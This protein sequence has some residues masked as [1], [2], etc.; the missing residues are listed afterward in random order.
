MRPCRPTRGCR[1]TIGPPSDRRM[2]SPMA[3]RNGEVR[4]S[5]TSAPKTSI[6]RFATM[7]RIRSG[8]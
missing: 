3:S 8:P 2:A 4:T 6:S 7:L 1:K 5:S